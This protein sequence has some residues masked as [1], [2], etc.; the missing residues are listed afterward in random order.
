MVSRR[1]VVLWSLLLLVVGVPIA[2]LRP[3]FWGTQSGSPAENLPLAAVNGPQKTLVI[4]VDFSDKGNST[5]PSQIGGILGGLNDYYREDSYGL[6]SF[7][8]NLTPSSGSWYIMPQPM[9]Y[10]GADTTSSDSQ[11][12]HDALQAAYSAGVNL[13]NYKFSIVVHA[14]GDEA[15]PPHATSDIHSFTI[16]GY[17]FKPSVLTSYTISSSVVSE[18]DPVGVFSHECGHL[19]GLPD[20]YDLTQR[21]D[22]ANNFVGYWEIMALGE[23]DPNTGSLVGPQPGT[24]PSHMSSWSKIQLGFVSAPSIANVTAGESK[25]IT[26]QNLET[27]TSGVQVVKIPIAFNRDGTSTYYLLE[28][29][30]KIGVYDQYLPFAAGYPGAGL[31]IYMVNESIANGMGSIRLIDAHPGGDLSDAPFGPCISPCVSNNT[32]WDQSNFVKVIVTATTPTAYSLVVDRTTSP[33]ELL[34]VNTPAIGVLVS[35]DGVNSTTD[36]SKEVRI[37]VHHGPHTVFVQPRIPISIGSTIVQVGLTNAFS[38]WDDGGTS[39]PRG[40]TVTRDIVITAIYRI[41]AEPSAALA[42]VAVVF[43]SVVAAGVTLH[44][45]KSH[46]PPIAPQLPIPPIPT[47]APGS[48]PALASFPRNDGLLEETGKS[49]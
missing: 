6:V 44:R 39:D 8:T 17:I 9:T 28:M 19:L 40:L 30:A 38:S 10:Y 13:A 12:I 7:D 49:E 16:P 27:P 22:P 43:L 48:S 34:Q 35:V 29:R 15:M 47:P 42:I 36:S 4:L 5:S 23:W 31:L 33:V 46:R 3:P 18:S 45:R 24:Y 14:G 1:P 25:N 26:V 32:F 41:S 37:P 11:L 2:A 20:L 21:I